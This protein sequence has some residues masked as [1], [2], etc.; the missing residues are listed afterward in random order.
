[1]S[2]KSIFRILSLCF[3]FIFFGCEDE[4]LTS[5]EILSIEVTHEKLNTS[6]DITFEIVVIV[7]GSLDNNELNFS[8]GDGSD[9]MVIAPY[10]VSDENGVINLKYKTTHVYPGAGNYVLELWSDLLPDQ[11]FQKMITIDPISGT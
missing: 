7:N 5:P 6:N 11:K 9:P 1:M 2:T 3:A 8:V 4:S 10:S